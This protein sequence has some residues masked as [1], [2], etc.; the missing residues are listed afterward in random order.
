MKFSSLFLSLVSFSCRTKLVSEERC[1]Y[2]TEQECLPLEKEKCKNFPETVCDVV[3]VTRSQNQCEQ[4][5]KVQVS[6]KI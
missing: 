3:N 1:Q 4:V 5:E 6:Q 2:V